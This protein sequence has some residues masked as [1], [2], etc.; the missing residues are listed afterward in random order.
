MNEGC[1]FQGENIRSEKKSRAVLSTPISQDTLHM[2]GCMNLKS[3]R[4][5]KCK[6]KAQLQ[7]KNYWIS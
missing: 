5:F 4:P 2:T 6:I 7:Y 1:E 3:N